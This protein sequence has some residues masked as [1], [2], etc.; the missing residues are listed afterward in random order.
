MNVLIVEN[1]AELAKSLKTSIESWNYRAEVSGGARQGIKKLRDNR[2]DVV[3][4]DLCLPDSPGK[5]LISR[6]KREQPGIGVIAMTKISSREIELNARTQ[7]ILYYM[8][9]PPQLESL[10]NILDHLSNFNGGS[11]I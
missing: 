6:I 3:L 2:F 11:L 5:D 9:K 10:K 8:I 4:L 7:G 1:E